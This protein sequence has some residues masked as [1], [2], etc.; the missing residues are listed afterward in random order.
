MKSTREA[1]VTDSTQKR[2]GRW[3]IMKTRSPVCSAKV[4]A[5]KYRRPT[6][7]PFHPCLLTK[8]NYNLPTTG[9]GLEKGTYLNDT[10]KRIPASSTGY[11]TGLRGE[12]MTGCRAG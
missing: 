10:A 7:P 9:W 3:R 6:Y 4:M 5:I 12:A 1:G 2:L 11:V 8:N